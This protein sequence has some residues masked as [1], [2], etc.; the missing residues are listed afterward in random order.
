MG[1]EIRV[2]IQEFEPT[3]A[4]SSI[5]IGVRLN[6]QPKSSPFDAKG[7]VKQG[8]FFPL[9]PSIAAEVLSLV[10]IAIESDSQAANTVKQAV[11]QDLALLFRGSTDGTIS[12]K[13]RR[14]QNALRKSLFR[15]LKF[16][17]CGIC[18]REFP[19]KLLHA[20]HIKP[21]NE[22]SHEER[23]D[24]NVV[25][26]ACLFG[27]DALFERG[28]I[29]VNAHGFI[30][31]NPLFEDSKTVNNY[32]EQIKGNLAPSHSKSNSKYF[33]WHANNARLNGE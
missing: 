30:E 4:I 23:L 16:E 31:T 12:G 13:Y 17:S 7:M 11:E 26:P 1:R 22:C 29:T 6:T 10:G 19:I 32:L 33:E 15:N 14:E 25:I 27:C 28:L 2:D 5:P 24:R 21:R 18:G 20:A 3:I 8:Y 9:A